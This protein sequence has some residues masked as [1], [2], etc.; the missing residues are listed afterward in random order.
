MT[1]HALTFSVAGARLGL[2]IDS[3]HEVLPS[4]KLSLLP[5]M[6]PLVRGFLTLDQET[7]PVIRLETFL[8]VPPLPDSLGLNDRIIVANLPGLRVAWV[9]E[10]H[11]EPI[12]YRRAE[13]LPVPPGLILNGCALGLLATTP[14]T[15]LLSP[16][17]LL[18]EAETQWLSELQ[19]RTQER[20]SHLPSLESLSTDPA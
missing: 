19:Q 15:A 7:I 18:M 11:L 3:V 13:L 9:T 8:N 20:L 1:H 10:P 2:D 5:E 6:P 17:R 14:P 16:S 12:T 4:L